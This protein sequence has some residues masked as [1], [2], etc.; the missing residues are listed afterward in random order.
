MGSPRRVRGGP[1]FRFADRRSEESS[2]TLTADER[3]YLRDLAWKGL[4]DRVAGRETSP[5]SVPDGPL[6]EPGSAFV[7][8]LKNGRLRG[9]IGM[10]GDRMPL[11]QAVLTAARSVVED[12][13]FPPLSEGELPDVTLSISRLGPFRE[14]GSLQDLEVG[15]H[16]VY[17]RD[18]LRSA[19]LLPRVASDRGWDRDRLL[20]E[21]CRKAGLSGDRWRE[22]GLSVEVFTA[23]E[24]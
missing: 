16:G 20:T 11:W 8:L 18:D 6:A 4:R 1:F 21:V 14:V 3:S 5:P 22:P 9:C 7:T 24:F 17:V 19:L 2:V 23:E 13:R 12:P 15:T 10:I